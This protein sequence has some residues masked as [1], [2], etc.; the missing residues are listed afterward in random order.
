VFPERAAHQAAL[1]Q[2]NLRAGAYL[3]QHELTELP[4]DF[5]PEPEE[6]TKT[7]AEVIGIE[8]PRIRVTLDR[9]G[10]ARRLI[11]QA[12]LATALWDL[13]HKDAHKVMRP[14]H[15]APLP[16]S[17]AHARADHDDGAWKREQERRDQ[18]VY[19][20]SSVREAALAEAAGLDIGELVLATTLM[21]CR[22]GVH[23]HEADII[24]K[25]LGLAA[26][27]Q[28]R[29]LYLDA[30]NAALF[31]HARS[32]LTDKKTKDKDRLLLAL[33]ILVERPAH[34]PSHDEVLHEI[35]GIDI[36]AARKQGRARRKEERAKGP[37][38]GGVG[39]TSDADVDGNAARDE[40][41]DP[42]DTPN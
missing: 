6:P 30:P 12:D 16:G 41:I 38:G 31:A 35:L 11:T 39:G 19:E 5:E 13:G 23:Y 22:Y 25:E 3:E 33:R 15:D 4:E 18:R 27:K 36:K 24:R 21:V 40:V 17:P 42:A 28:N 7:W 32:A 2:W 37:T 26:G 8:H 10:H 9:D 34:E 29:N 20:A 1:E 14:L